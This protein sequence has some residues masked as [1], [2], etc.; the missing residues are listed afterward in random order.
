LREKCEPA[1]C[2]VV[3]QCA[4]GLGIPGGGVCACALWLLVLCVS[5]QAVRALVAR[6]AAGMCLAAR[7]C[8][9]A[10][11]C[12]CVCVNVCE[13]AVN[14]V[15]G[16]CHKACTAWRAPQ[17]TQPAC[18]HNARTMRAQC[19]HAPTLL[20]DPRE[21]TPPHHSLGPECAHERSHAVHCVAVGVGLL[22]G[23]EEGRGLD[24]QLRVCMCACV[25]V[26]VCACVCVWGGGGGSGVF[27]SVS[28][29][30]RRRVHVH[31]MLRC[32][33]RACVHAGHGSV[34]SAAA[35][36]PSCARQLRRTA[37][38]AWQ[39]HTHTHLGVLGQPQQALPLV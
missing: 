15:G 13:R 31:S 28:V 33:R 26:C 12:V 24:V 22:R 11:V 4:P 20:R 9:C 37:R 14:W 34:L 19:T 35:Q 39:L 23:A 6:H 1:G 21:V 3:I 5:R 27:F 17:Q 10:C 36:P 7:V 16:L 25:R 38:S 2:L 18:A 8:V 32:S 30:A 29:S